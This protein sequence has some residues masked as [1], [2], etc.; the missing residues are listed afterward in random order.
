MKY[1]G[2]QSAITSHHPP[3]RN[4]SYPPAHIGTNANLKSHCARVQ[5]QSLDDLSR[6]NNNPLESSFM[7]ICILLKYC[8]ATTALRRQVE[9]FK[10]YAHPPHHMDAHPSSNLVTEVYDD[11]HCGAYRIHA[12]PSRVVNTCAP[13]VACAPRPVL[14]RPPKLGV[15]LPDKSYLSS[16][17]KGSNQVDRY[18][19]VKSEDYYPR[20]TCGD[21]DD[22]VVRLEDFGSPMACRRDLICGPQAVLNGHTV[23]VVGARQ[24]RRALPPPPPPGHPPIYA[25][26]YAR[27]HAASAVP[28]EIPRPQL[29]PLRSLGADIPRGPAP[30]DVPV[31]HGRVRGVVP[32]TFASYEA[33]VAEQA[34]AA[35]ASVPAAPHAPFVPAH[36]PPPPPP[37]VGPEVVMA[38]FDRAPPPH[39]P[40]HAVVGATFAGAGG[41]QGNGVYQPQSVH[42]R[43]DGSTLPVPITVEQSIGGVRTFVPA[44]TEESAAVNVSGQ[45]SGRSVHLRARS[46]TPQPIPHGVHYED[47]RG[48][49][50]AY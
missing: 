42:R 8:A 40:A 15:R 32:P 41:V 33:L 18:A 28:S 23:E 3:D 6:Y 12:A 5:A 25:H 44:S 49:H 1:H 36:M 39:M 7:V 27:S 26:S 46:A 31:I 35:A 50:V 22:S 19:N 9:K 24:T 10:M 48:I 13:I 17:N 43:L 16:R 14:Y 37:M 30:H 38:P 2:Y 29:V 34:A 20:G 11:A 47:P 21:F 45:P 4:T